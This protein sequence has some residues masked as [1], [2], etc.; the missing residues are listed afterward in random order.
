M[1]S[2]GNHP[3][4]FQMTKKEKLFSTITLIVMVL[5][6]I[7]YISTDRSDNDYYDYSETTGANDFS[8]P[9][10]SAVG[11]SKPEPPKL[12]KPEPP[13]LIKP[14]PPKLIKPEPPSN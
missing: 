12:I 2:G 6:F 8:E 1:E 14:E 3:K 5:I 4:V 7:F 13:K 11:I 10:D 9:T